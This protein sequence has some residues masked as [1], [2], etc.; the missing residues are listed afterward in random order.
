MIQHTPPTASPNVTAHIWVNLAADLRAHTVRLLAQLAYAYA[1]SPIN[2]SAKES[3]DAVP[4]DRR[5]DPSR[6]S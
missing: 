6:P 2:H 1:T 5:Q 3:T 4:S